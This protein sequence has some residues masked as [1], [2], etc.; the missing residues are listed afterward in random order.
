MAGKDSL[1]DVCSNLRASISHDG[2]ETDAGVSSEELNKVSHSPFVSIV[3][4]LF[5]FNLLD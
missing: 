5:F 2:D 3:S 4:K 1:I